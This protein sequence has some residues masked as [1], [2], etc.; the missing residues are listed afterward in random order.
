[1][2]LGDMAKA[3]GFEKEEICEMLELFVQTTIADLEKINFA[4]DRSLPELAVEA[5]HS[6]KGAARSFRFEEIAEAAARIE[7]RA[8]QQVLE[9]S[10]ETAESIKAYLDEI[11]LT[12]QDG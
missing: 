7:M 6:I 10:A 3:L 5:A 8:R 11:I 9:G 2:N 1:M 12:L 4:I